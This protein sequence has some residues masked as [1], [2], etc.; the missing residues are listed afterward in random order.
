MLATADELLSCYVSLQTIV[1]VR[2]IRNYLI[3]ASLFHGYRH[4]HLLV[5]GLL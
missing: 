4:H 2:R 1:A 3:V 5:F